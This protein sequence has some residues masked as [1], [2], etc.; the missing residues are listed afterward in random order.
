MCMYYEW[1]IENIRNTRNNSGIILRIIGKI[2]RIVR[3]NNRKLKKHN[4]LVPIAQLLLSDYQTSPYP[5]GEVGAKAPP[6]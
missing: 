2:K 1:E 6:S 5:G 3:K 4:R